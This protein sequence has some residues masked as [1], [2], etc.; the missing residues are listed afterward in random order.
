[1]PSTG[2]ARA[3]TCAEKGTSYPRTATT[4]LSQDRLPPVEELARYDLVVVDSEWAHR[5]PRRYFNQLRAADPG[6][7]ILAYVNLVDHPDQLG[8]PK[9]WAHRYSL[10]R[11]QD[12]KTSTFPQQWLATTSGGKQVS[13]FANSSMANL[14]DHAPRIDGQTYA[15]YAAKWVDET[16]WSTGLWDGVFLDVWGD[17]IY[18]AD[19]DA[20][21]SDGDGVDEPADAIYGAR[22]PWAR[23][24]RLAERIMRARMPGA[25]LVANGD[26]TLRDSNL[27]GLVW[28]SFVDPHAG[29]D[30]ADDFRNYVTSI[31]K[32]EHRR[33]GVSVTINIRRAPKGSATDRKAARFRLA[34]TLM[35]DGFWAPMGANY[36]ELGSYDELDGGGLGR[37]YL[38]KPL[39][40][41]P[42]W[43]ALQDPF[44]DGVGSLEPQLFRRDF[45]N[46]IVLL[47]TG[48]ST[49][50][51]S[52]E[53]AYLR[54]KGA[55][56]TKPKDGTRTTSVSIA[57]KDGLVLVRP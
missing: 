52:L 10:W 8:T 40:K 35:Q 32:G 25:I 26:R 7:C 43:A 24:A 38:G 23:G 14:T 11:F 16:V 51:V 49:R 45:E 37:G 18:T 9:Y 6:V 22:S 42:T 46:G 5:A 53:R 57:P 39:A 29:R 19:V 55:W 15:E 13:E 27:D 33:P 21:D 12:S 50:T 41:S 3:P 17:R 34:S 2:N 48:T 28:E 56:G 54:V 31:A 4:Y 36:G 1:M 20:W 47:N 44:V 30:P